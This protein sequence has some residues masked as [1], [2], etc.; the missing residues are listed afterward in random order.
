M[1]ESVSMSDLRE[2]PPSVL[3]PPPEGRRRATGTQHSPGARVHPVL[4]SPPLP[5]E[6]SQSLDL[7]QAIIN[8]MIFSFI[9]VFSQ[10]LYEIFPSNP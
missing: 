1:F 9:T 2:K 6:E 7:C 8:H 10:I 3:E 4:Q 5:T